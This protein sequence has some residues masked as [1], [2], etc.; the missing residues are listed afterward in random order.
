MIGERGERAGVEGRHEPKPRVGRQRERRRQKAEL[1]E[2]EPAVKRN[3]RE[4]P[5]DIGN[6]VKGEPD[7]GEHL[8]QE[9]RKA[10]A[11]V[12]RFEL[13]DD[14]RVAGAERARQ[15]NHREHEVTAD[16]YLARV[17][18]AALEI[19]RGAAWRRGIDRK[20]EIMRE[21]YAMLNAESQA[22]RAEA[23]EIA[24][25]LLIVLEVVLSFVRE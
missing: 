20:L 1:H 12:P 19:F 24:I 9:R 7:A 18:S 3:G 6:P 22:V 2:H 11:L 14:G 16:V 23:L 5:A 15:H 21:T 8:Q 10:D 17:Y 13:A 4:P 25:V